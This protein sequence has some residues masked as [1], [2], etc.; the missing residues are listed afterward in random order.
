MKLQKN[1]YFSSWT[2]RQFPNDGWIETKLT[3]QTIKHL[4]E[5][6]KKKSSE[7]HNP[8]LA[9]HISH[10]YQIQDKDQLFTTSVLFRF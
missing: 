10:S 1:K 4:K 8:H 9:G 7:S 2:S 5:C 6:I 3:D